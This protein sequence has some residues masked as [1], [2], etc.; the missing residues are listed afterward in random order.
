MSLRLYMDV[1][2]RIEITNG[3]RRR[4]VEVLTAPEDAARRLADPQ[5][6]DR[7][8]QLRRVLFSHDPDLIAEAA[9]RQFAG[10]NFAGIIYAHQLG[11][12]IGQCIDD[13]ELVAKV[14]EPQDIENAILYLPLR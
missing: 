12:T 11:I 1:N 9:A 8:T 14:Y 5:S 2:D 7:A 10:R 13:L 4:G 6:L 3:L